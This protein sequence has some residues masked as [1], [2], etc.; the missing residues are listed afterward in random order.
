[1]KDTDTKTCCGIWTPVNIRML[2]NDKE[3]FLIL[4]LNAIWKLITLDLLIFGVLAEIFTGGM[5][6]DRDMFTYPYIYTH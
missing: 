5:V 1:M 2:I 4:L 6:S 3:Y